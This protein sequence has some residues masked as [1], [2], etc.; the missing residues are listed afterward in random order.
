MNGAGKKELKEGYVQLRDHLEVLLMERE[1]YFNVRFDALYE[2]LKLARY[3]LERRLE[4]LNELRKDVEKD[5]ELLLRKEAFE[6]KIK[7]Y[8]EWIPQVNKRLTVM[9]TRSVVWTAAIAIFFILIN[10]ALRIWK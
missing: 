10:I 1:K 9:E 5:R 6:D 3:D 7:F 8:D 4:G 2:N